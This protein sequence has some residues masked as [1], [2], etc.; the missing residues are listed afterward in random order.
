[1]SIWHILPVN[2]LEQHTEDSTCKCNPELQIIDNGDM[3]IVHNS[4][5]KRELKEV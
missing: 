5:D 4:F 1:M 3:M 2:D